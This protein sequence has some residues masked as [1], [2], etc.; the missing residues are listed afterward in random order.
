MNAQKFFKA[1]GIIAC[2]ILLVLQTTFLAMYLVEYSS[3][4]GISFVGLLLLLV[5][6]AWFIMIGRC[7][8]QL[9]QLWVVWGLY[10]IDLVVF[11]AIIFGTDVRERLDKDKFWSPN[12]LKITI[13][14]APAVASLLITT[15]S[16]SGKY[17]DLVK[18]L[19]GD[20]ALDL[21]DTIEALSIV[22]APEDPNDV[23]SHLD[24]SLIYAII[25]IVGMGLLLSPLEMAEKGFLPT[26]GQGESKFRKKLTLCR[27]LLEMLLVNIALMIVRLIAWKKYNHEASIFIAKN[28]I[29]V[30]VSIV[31]VIQLSKFKWCK[32][33]DD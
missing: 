17:G 15:A 31:E 9:S 1:C 8:S 28:A 19:C 21:F 23:S 32:F 33:D 30:V 18:Q 5:L 22:I 3:I 7:E 11:F 14:I 26:T 27:L 24:K 25:A 13:C 20:I 4:D 6:F 29:I 16:D 12:N 10:A 2:I